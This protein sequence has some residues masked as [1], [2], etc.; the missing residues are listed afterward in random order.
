[1]IVAQG[2]RFAG[3]SLYVKDGVV[4]YCHNYFDLEYSYVEASEKL[5]SGTVNV[6]YHFDYEGGG[7]GK[8]GVGKLYF[9]DKLVGEGRITKTVPMIFSADET[10]DLGGDLALPVTDDYAVGEANEFQGTV[11]WVRIDLEDDDHSHMIP[12]DQVYKAMIS[13]Q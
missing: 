10:L 3:W 2:G 8:G 12:D 6:R 11:N 4:K 9:D 7:T 5:P 1:V 13:R